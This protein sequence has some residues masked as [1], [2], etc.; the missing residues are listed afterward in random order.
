MGK[1]TCS[2]AMHGT[3]YRYGTGTDLVELG[4]DLEED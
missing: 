1:H 4:C 2:N 3:R